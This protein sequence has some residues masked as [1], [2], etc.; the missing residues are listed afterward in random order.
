VTREETIDRAYEA[1]T[2]RDLDVLLSLTHSESEARPILGANIGTGVYRG[3]DGL[4]EWMHDLHG[5]WETFESRVTAI[6][7]RGDRM[8]CTIDVRAQGRASG[9]AIEG[10][11][12]HLLEFREGLIWRLEAFLD[13]SAAV[14]ALGAT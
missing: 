6:E 3:H 10:E 7:E 14:Q 8:L 13:H 12:Y 1:W 4:R 2:R 5:E 9:A 11:M